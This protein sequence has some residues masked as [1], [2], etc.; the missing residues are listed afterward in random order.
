MHQQNSFQE[1]TEASSNN[2]GSVQFKYT[3]I[4]TVRIPQQKFYIPLYWTK[5]S[6]TYSFL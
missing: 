3:I 5:R 6:S 1:L 2:C 4:K